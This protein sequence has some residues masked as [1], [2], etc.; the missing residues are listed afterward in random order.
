VNKFQINY[1]SHVNKAVEIEGIKIIRYE[2]SIF[3]ANVD[4]FVYR[5]FKL[6]GLNPNDVI[7]AMKKKREQFAKDKRKAEHMKKVFEIIS[8]KLIYKPNKII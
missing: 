3:Y 4:N 7:E 5:I 2:S 1:I 6:S 8:N